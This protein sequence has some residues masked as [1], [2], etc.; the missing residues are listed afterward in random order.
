MS[1]GETAHDACARQQKEIERIRQENPALLERDRRMDPDI[2][3]AKIG[4]SGLDEDR[5]S[6]Y[7][8]YHPYDMITEERQRGGGI[9]RPEPYRSVPDDHGTINRILHAHLTKVDLSTQEALARVKDSLGLSGEMRYAHAK[10][11]RGQTSQRVSFEGVDWRQIEGQ[12]VPGIIL[13]PIAYEDEHV[14][15]DDHVGDRFT[16]LVRH[17]GS[18]HSERLKYLADL[19]RR[20]GFLNFIPQHQFGSRALAHKL[21][22]QL[23]RG[24]EKR[25]LQTFLTHPGT[26]DLPLFRGVR[27]RLAANFGDWEAMLQVVEPFSHSLAAERRV[28]ESLHDHPKKTR[29][30]LHAIRSHA[31]RWTQAYGNWLINRSLT[32]GSRFEKILPEQLARDP[33]NAFYDDLCS[34]DGVFDAGESFKRLGLKPLSGEHRVRVRPDI[35]RITQLDQGTLFQFSLPVG[36]DPYGFLLQFYRLHSGLPVPGWVKGGIV[37]TLRFQVKS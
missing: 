25:C 23:A 32:Q 22:C 16:V 11:H 33:Q 37:D 2:V 35:H 20:Y 24:D 3:L 9:S 6:G 13:E 27:E 1:P 10:S 15:R 34:Q 7:L 5:P 29:R 18:E 19:Y 17:D 31:Q 4:I 12:E 30:A 36:S 26:H 21:G 8:H 14:K 28:L